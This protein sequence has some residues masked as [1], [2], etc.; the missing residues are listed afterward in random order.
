MAAVARG[1]RQHL[2]ATVPRQRQSAAR[3]KPKRPKNRVQEEVVAA[4][5]RGERQQ[6]HATGGASVR[7]KKACR[8][9]RV[10]LL[11]EA[12][13]GMSW[14]AAEPQQAHYPRR[15]TMLLPC[16]AF[17]PWNTLPL[18]AHYQT[19]GASRSR[20]LVFLRPFADAV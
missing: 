3:R 19:C 13:R 14:T 18:P 8:G 5:A 12:D 2:P 1:E 11:P 15:P 16:A 6:L 10:Y 9:H 7:R 20:D 4:V 17:W